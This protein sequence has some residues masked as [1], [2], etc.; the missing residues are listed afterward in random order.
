[1]TCQQLNTAGPC[2]GNRAKLAASLHSDLITV[3]RDCWYLQLQ[4][5]LSTKDDFILIPLQYIL[6]I[7]AECNVYT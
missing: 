1:M 6:L 5:S 4:I 7:C 2:I 3:I